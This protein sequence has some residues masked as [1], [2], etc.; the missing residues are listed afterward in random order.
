MSNFGVASYADV[1]RFV[2]RSSPPSWGGTRD[3]RPKNVCREAINFGEEIFS[4]N[5]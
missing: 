1:L 2:T 5:L 3:N 4:P